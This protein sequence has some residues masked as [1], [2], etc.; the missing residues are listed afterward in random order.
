M[1]LLKIRKRIF[2]IVILVMI[3]QLVSA[4]IVY[5]DVSPN[6]TFSGSYNLDLNND[7]TIDFVSTQKILRV[8]LTVAY[9]VA[10]SC[11]VK[12]AGRD[13]NRRSHFSLSRFLLF[14]AVKKFF[15]ASG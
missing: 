13:S 12:K 3:K 10:I 9:A 14:S 11:G 2:F 5:T 15:K 7:G 1:N 4:Q 8:A 6:I